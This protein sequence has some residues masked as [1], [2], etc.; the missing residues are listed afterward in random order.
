MK[1]LSYLAIGVACLFGLAVIPAT[2][3]GLYLSFSVSV[4]LGLL[5]LLVEP[6]PTVIGFLAF[7]GHPEVA[8]KIAEWLHLV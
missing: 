1:L 7:F 5:V 2:I 6:S 8:K 3:Y 4:V